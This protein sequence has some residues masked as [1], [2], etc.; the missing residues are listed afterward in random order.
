K[1][2]GLALLRV[3]GV[4][5]VRPLP[6]GD[7]GRADV[8]LVGIA[9]PQAQA[10]NAAV[11]TVKVRLAAANGGGAFEPAMAQGFAGAAAIDSGAG[12]S[13]VA[14]QRLGGGANTPTLVPVEAIRKLLAEENVS[15][16]SGKIAPDAA[17]D[18]VVRTICV[19]K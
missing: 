11:S 17:K 6:L 15:F 8:T 4:L 10:G 5:D 12:F 1:T 9:D 19:R 7:G 14:V 3:Y 18:S 16:V 2:S 13:G